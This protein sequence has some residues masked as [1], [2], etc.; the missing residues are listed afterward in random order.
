MN[1]SS[2]TCNIRI[3][4]DTMKIIST[5]HQLLDEKNHRI[6]QLMDIQEKK[7]KQVVP[8]VE[9]VWKFQLNKLKSEN[10]KLTKMNDRLQCQL[11]VEKPTVDKQT[12]TNYHEYQ[13][14]LFKLDKVLSH[15]VGN[16]VS[17]IE[18]FNSNF[19]QD[20]DMAVKNEDRIS[21]IYMGLQSLSDHANKLAQDCKDLKYKCDDMESE[22]KSL[23][24]MQNDY[25]NRI[26][27]YKINR[28]TPLLKGSETYQQIQPEVKRSQLM[29]S[30][31]S[32]NNQLMDHSNKQRD[33]VIVSMPSKNCMLNGNRG[34][35]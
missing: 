3:N 4:T 22:L 17:L 29:E 1:A 11:T 7:R 35:C 19:F 20:I 31:E 33:E 28:S 5:L 16:L 6:R 14:Q 21:F 23:T 9:V 32:C 12:Q 18:H 30:H 25:M 8:E 10:E 2:Q 26:P 15:V 27:A 13:S 24:H 34:I